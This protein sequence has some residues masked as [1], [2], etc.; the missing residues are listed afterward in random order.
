MT[1]PNPGVT[2][3]PA[4]HGIAPCELAQQVPPLVFNLGSR[5]AHCLYRALRPHLGFIER[6]A[7]PSRFRVNDRQVGIDGVSREAVRAKTCELRMAPVTPC[8]P[9]Q[10]RARQQRFAPESDQALRIEVAWMDRPETQFRPL[11]LKACRQRAS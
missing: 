2:Q 8:L 11:K 7:A 3:P 6:V 1:S 5:C 10:D 9:S 4:A